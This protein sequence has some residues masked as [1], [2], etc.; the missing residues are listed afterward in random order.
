VSGAVVE[1]NAKVNQAKIDAFV[2]AED[3]SGAVSAGGQAVGVDY[4]RASG[5]DAVIVM[6]GKCA[7]GAITGADPGKSK[8]TAVNAGGVGF[9]ILTLSASGTHPEAKAAADHVAIGGQQIRFDGTRI[10]FAKMAGPL[11][12]RQ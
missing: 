8:V 6:V 12:I 10:V 4:S 9:S 3:G 1:G 11:K 5:A 2:A 7:T